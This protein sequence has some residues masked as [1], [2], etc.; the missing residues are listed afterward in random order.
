LAFKRGFNKLLRIQQGFEQG[1]WNSTGGAH[2]RPQR[3]QQ[4]DGIGMAGAGSPVQGWRGLVLVWRVQQRR[5][6]P[7][8][9]EGFQHGPSHSTGVSKGSLK[10]VPQAPGA[11]AA[12]AP[13]AGHAPP[14]S[15]A[16]PAPRGRAP[17]GP[18]P[19]AARKR[20]EGQFA[21]DSWRGAP[22]VAPRAEGVH[23]R[24]TTTPREGGGYVLAL[25][26]Y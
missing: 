12:P 20:K 15:P 7:H 22:V 10:R 1:P 25:P 4:L 14:R 19:D 17:T 8:L 26:L 2:V 23:L 24:S 3:E 6:Q 11:P 9:Q 13:A 16:R 21:T 5:H 18:C